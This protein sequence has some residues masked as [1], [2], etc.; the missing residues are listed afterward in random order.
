MEDVMLQT[1]LLVLRHGFAIAASWVLLVSAGHAG[2]CA[3]RLQG[4]QERAVGVL[5]SAAEKGRSAGEGTSA[6]MHRQPTPRSIA[7]A[8]EKLGEL[9]REKVEA[10]RAAFLRA[11]TAEAAG[12]ETGCQN[13]AGVAESLLREK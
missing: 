2:E 10:F 7:E 1:N 8:E 6:T 5:E 12:D 11:R 3:S 9:P 4:L 13:A